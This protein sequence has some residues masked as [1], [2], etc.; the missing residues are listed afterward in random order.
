M[1]I[2]F[3]IGNGFDV[4]LGMK[5][6]FKDFFPVYL[7]QSEKKPQEIKRL[8]K[9]IKNDFQTWSDFELQ[10]GQY[11]ALF[12]SGEIGKIIQQFRD[13]QTEFMKYLKEKQKE[14][15]FQDKTAIA[16]LMLSALKGFYTTTNLQN[17][18]SETIEKIFRAR[19]VEKRQFHFI[20]FNYTCALEN[21]L[22]TIPDRLV[23]IRKVGKSTIKDVVGKIIHVHGTERNVPIMGVGDSYQIANKEL[24]SNERFLRYFVKP[25]I[26]AA[27]RTNQDVETSTLISNST[28]ICVYGMSLGATDK[29]WWNEVLLWLKENSERQLV[30]FDYDPEFSNTSQFDWIEKEYSILDKL[31]SYNNAS[32]QDIEMLRPRIHI[33][34]NKNIF[35]MDLRMK[36]VV[37]G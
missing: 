5:T 25:K 3:M 30:I 19:A 26:N 12:G 37:L 14:L 17:R 20:S 16:E 36:S 9:E 31:A 10:M 21:C 6:G 33:A 18:S 23:E 4:G 32:E 1:N 15:S 35:E 27:H 28:I 22:D 7:A 11:T 2:T 24:A 34:V 13:F 8:A 29:N